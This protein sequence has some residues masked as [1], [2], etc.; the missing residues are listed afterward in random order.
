M[1]TNVIGPF[2]SDGKHQRILGIRPI[3]SG[4]RAVLVL[5]TEHLPLLI[6]CCLDRITGIILDKIFCPLAV[7][8]KTSTTFHIISNAKTKSI[9]DFDC[10]LVI[11]SRSE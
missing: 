2:L 4:I 3:C 9:S 10:F 11:S 8:N 5:Q 1:Y 6:T 7:D